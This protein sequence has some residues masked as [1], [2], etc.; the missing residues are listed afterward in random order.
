MGRWVGGE[1]ERGGFVVL[2]ETTDYMRL[3]P[4]AWVF[5]IISSNRLERQGEGKR[6]WQQDPQE[7]VR[8]E[9]ARQENIR[10]E[11]ELCGIL[12]SS[13]SFRGPWAFWACYTRI[14]MASGTPAIHLCSLLS[15]GVL[16]LT[17]I[18]DLSLYLSR[19]LVHRV[20]KTDVSES[21]AVGSS[22]RHVL[23]SHPQPEASHHCSCCTP[24]KCHPQKLSL[25]KHS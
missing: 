2:R 12:N 13:G 24:P 18:S 3:L 22:F 5:P 11:E 19:G 8:G 25:G 7:R 4:E 17:T 15:V 23:R 9:E 14:D 16:E 1:P 20:S 21:A 6:R 10:K